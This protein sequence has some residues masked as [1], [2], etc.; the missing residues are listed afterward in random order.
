MSA[1]TWVLLRGLARERG[2]WGSLPAWLAARVVPAEV[3]AL[4]LPGTGARHAERSPATVDAIVDA[5]RSELQRRCVAPPY[6]LL[7]LSLGGM[8]ALA[9]SQR[10]AA[11]VA[12][13]IVMNCS[14]RNLG[15]WHERLRPGK[16]LSLLATRLAGGPRRAE[17][18][19]LRC[20]SA[21][22]Q[23]HAAVVDGWV[24]LRHRHPVAIP[25]L[26]RQLL[27]ASRWRV[28]D[29]APAVPLLLLSSAGDR[30]VAPQCTHR[31]A[32]RWGVPH[33]EHPRAGHDLPLDAP[34]WVIAQALA[35]IVLSPGHH[36]PVMP[37]GDDGGR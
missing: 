23:R 13:C 2:H 28:P 3:V 5:C 9:W 29:R 11:E 20:T 36:A 31:L 22:P 12:S 25:N 6:R 15:A 34:Q 32:A 10:F 16:A 7:G 21:D 30:L 27:A 33:A 17:L 1:P 19:V 37:A 26:L 4:D 14:A 18:A 8:V 24:A 35:F